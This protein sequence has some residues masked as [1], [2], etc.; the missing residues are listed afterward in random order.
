MTEMQKRQPNQDHNFF[1]CSPTIALTVSLSVPTTG[2]CGIVGCSDV[3][4]GIT[5]MSKPIHIEG[6]IVRTPSEIQLMQQE[7]LADH[8]DYCMFQRIVTGIL[9]SSKDETRKSHGNKIQQQ[10]EKMPYHSKKVLESIVRTRNQPV[11]SYSFQI[12]E[13]PTN[14]SASIGN[15]VAGSMALTNL[16]TRPFFYQ[17]R[18][19]EL[20]ATSHYYCHH[21]RQMQHVMSESA[22]VTSPFGD[23]A[24]DW[25][26]SHIE[27]PEFF[28]M[29]DL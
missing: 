7:V 5:A 13:S 15:D 21:Q 16:A 10:V 2:P 20:L 23:D 29:D 19:N 25:L 27:D 8:R 26:A 9:S 22:S 28:S 4:N 1:A 24:N 17:Q 18:D 12:N 14:K 11:E 3:Q 6:S